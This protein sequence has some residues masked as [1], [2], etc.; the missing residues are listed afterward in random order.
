MRRML[1]HRPSPA[2]AV[3]LTAL[4][5]SLGGVSYGVATG[6]ID[7]REIKNSTIGNQD[8]RNNNLRGA[9]V[10]TGTLRGSDVAANTLTGLD[11][12]ESRLGTVPNAAQADN[13]TNA[14]NATNA[15]AL[16]G[17]GP[18]AFERSTRVQYGRGPSGGTTSTLLFS[19][20]QMGI[21]VR[22]DGDITNDNQVI[23]KNTNP[24]GGSAFN[25]SVDGLS[26]AFG[27]LEPG[28]QSETA[29]GPETAKAEIFV[30]EQGEPG[31]SLWIRCFFNYF[32]SGD[33]QTRC[34]GIRSQAS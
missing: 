23:L 6:S 32:G 18:G 1:R 27:A 3:A 22:T 25:Y 17:L 9:D 7:S 13:A 4:F 26:G 24:P 29:S 15:G 20:P 21:E 5:V 11:I 16:A 28:N 34:L 31:R 10:R 14:A 30:T 33:S 8:V 2:M 12:N 19:W